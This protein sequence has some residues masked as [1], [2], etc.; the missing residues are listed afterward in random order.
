[1]LFSVPYS[2]AMEKKG[3]LSYYLRMFIAPRRTFADLLNDEKRLR[4]GF[5]AALIPAI[6]YTLFY[7]MASQAGGAPSTFKPWLAI[8]AEDY[9]FWDIFLSTPGIFIS[10]I[11]ASGIIQLLSHLWNTS[12]SFEDTFVVISFG[13]GVASWST[14]LHDLIDAFL[15]FTGVIS[16][17][18]YERLLNDPGFFHNMLYTLFLIYFIWFPLLF[19]KGFSV[20]HKASTAKSVLLGIAGIIIYQGIL[21]IF[22]R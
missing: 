9:F 10:I 12:G 19:A 13:A 17:K 6:G 8:P 14:M 7:I 11:C 2:S 15:A 21:L 20:V 16:M 18:E 4:Y 22:I 1:M 5:F 3:F